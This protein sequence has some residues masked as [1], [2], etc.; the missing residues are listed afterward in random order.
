MIRPGPYVCAEWDFGGLPAR[1]L[2]IPNLKIRTRDPIY[3]AEVEVYTKSLVPILSPYLS[4]NGGPIVLLQ[5]ENEYGSFGNDLEYINALRQQW[6]D[7]GIEIEEY[8]ADSANNIEKSHWSG[9]N[10]GVNGAVTE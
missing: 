4:S 2:N 5:I 8:H 1:L 10:I 6:K 9:A 3:L 7:V